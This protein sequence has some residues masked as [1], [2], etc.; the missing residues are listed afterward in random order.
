MLNPSYLKKK[1]KIN[2]RPTNTLIDKKKLPITLE[3][4]VFYL[5]RF[6]RLNRL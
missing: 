4:Y 5:P 6:A 3:Q 1:N 2:P